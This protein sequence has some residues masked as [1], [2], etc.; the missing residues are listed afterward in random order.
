MY[1]KLNVSP[2]AI[3]NTRLELRE[4]YRELLLSDPDCLLILI[5]SRDICW[6][7]SKLMRYLNYIQ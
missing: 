5:Y 3:T 4:L 2:T 7:L 6:E 1:D